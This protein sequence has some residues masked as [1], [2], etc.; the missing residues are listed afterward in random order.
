MPS[1]PR[2]PPMQLPVSAATVGL[3]VSGVGVGVVEP[4]P[5][6][7]SVSAPDRWSADDTARLG[8]VVPLLRDFRADDAEAGELLPDGPNHKSYGAIGSESTTR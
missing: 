4:S 5:L 6:L 7:R 3:R 1:Q 2:I 8:L